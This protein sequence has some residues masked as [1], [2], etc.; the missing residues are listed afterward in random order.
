MLPFL[1]TGFWRRYTDGCP[2]SR[3]LNIILP[4]LMIDND[5]LYSLPVQSEKRSGLMPEKGAQRQVCKASRRRAVPELRR[6]WSLS[7]VEGGP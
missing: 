6:R 2:G 7:L 3:V 5:L 4:R 1:F